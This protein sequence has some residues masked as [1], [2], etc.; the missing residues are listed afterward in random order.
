MDIISHFVV[1]CKLEL[2]E[3]HNTIVVCFNVPLDSFGI[4]MGLVSSC[5]LVFDRDAVIVDIDLAIG[6]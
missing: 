3:I 2:F 4:R 1:L 5:H 6:Y